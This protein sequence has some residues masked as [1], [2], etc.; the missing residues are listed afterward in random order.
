M[1]IF[2]QKNS[3]YMIRS[4]RLQGRNHIVVPVV[5]MVEGVHSGNQGPI[6]HSAAE[7]GRIPE[8]WNGI[9][10]VINHPAVGGESVSA[11]SPEIINSGAVGR[12]FNT[13]MDG[14]KLRAEV[15]LDE[16]NL[17]QVSTD[18]LTYIREGQP[19]EVSIG[20]FNDEDGIPGE[21]KGE[22]YNA[23]AKNIRP[24]HLALLPGGTGAC[25]WEDGCGIRANKEGGNNEM[26][27]DDVIKTMK[28]LG[29]EGYSVTIIGI[30]Q[31]GFREIMSAI[32][33]KLD[34]MDTN[35]KM[36][37]LEEVFDGSCQRR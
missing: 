9:P 17:R 23:S 31:E 28:S 16:E 22:Q 10:V 19:L 33:T 12:V 3:D 2:A 24:D 1:K 4:E 20:A 37:F 15:W 8:S 36:H 25:S 34:Q 6:F 14:D 18:A 7:L 30:N 13:R 29:K 11:N 32:Q 27:N 26:K 5:M 21:W 35:T